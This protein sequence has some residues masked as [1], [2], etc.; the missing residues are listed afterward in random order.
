MGPGH[1][2]GLLWSLSKISGAHSNL[3][4]NVDG[5]VNQV[6]FPAPAPQQGVP[7]NFP[8]LETDETTY[9]GSKEA[10]SKAILSRMNESDLVLLPRLQMT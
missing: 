2:P 6:N 5:F 3:H 8:G 4:L 10:Y 9:I 1:T 7:E